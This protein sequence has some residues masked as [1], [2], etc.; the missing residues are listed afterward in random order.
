MEK[1]IEPKVLLLAAEKIRQLGEKQGE[2]YVFDH[3]QLEMSYDGYTITLKDKKVAITVFFHNKIKS[4]YRNMSDLEAF[5]Q[6]LIR[7]SELD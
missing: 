1:H 4:D 7:I 5:Y 3:V 2:D 6:R